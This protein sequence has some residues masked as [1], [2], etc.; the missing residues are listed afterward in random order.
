M[1]NSRRMAA[2]T[3][4]GMIAGGRAILG[5]SLALSAALHLADLVR[6]RDPQFLRLPLTRV[7][8]RELAVSGFFSIL[9]LAGLW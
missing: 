6:L 9:V 4:G 2:S 3:A 5:L 8:L 1:L 7:G